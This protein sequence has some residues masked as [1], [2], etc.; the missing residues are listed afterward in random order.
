[1]PTSHRI[2]YSISQPLNGTPFAF[3]PFTGPLLFF[4]VAPFS[5]NTN[6]SGLGT[7][8]FPFSQLVEPD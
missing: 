7:R 1:M 6:V 2:E 5:T 8:R 4:S 3:Q